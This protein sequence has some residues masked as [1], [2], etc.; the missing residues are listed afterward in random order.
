[1]LNKKSL[2]NQ[3]MIYLFIISITPNAL[4]HSI[5]IQCQE[6]DSLEASFE[7]NTGLKLSW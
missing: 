7:N 1:M 5:N 4:S 3:V 6:S 2:L